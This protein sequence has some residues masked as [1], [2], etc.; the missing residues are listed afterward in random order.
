MKTHRELLDEWMKEPEFV[1]E[2]DALAEEFALFDKMLKVQKR[3]APS[4][5][6]AKDKPRMVPSTKPVTS[7]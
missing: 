7:V 1:A 2:Y 6:T 5:H 4:F 3:W